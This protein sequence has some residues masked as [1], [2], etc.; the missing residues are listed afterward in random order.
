VGRRLDSGH[1]GEFQAENLPPNGLATKD[2]MTL[3]SAVAITTKILTTDVPS[4]AQPQLA[5]GEQAEADE[6]SP[7][8]TRINPDKSRD[9][10]VLIR[11]DEASGFVA[12]TRGRK[13]RPFDDPDRRKAEISTT[14]FTDRHEFQTNGSGLSVFIRVIRG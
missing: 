13:P 7:R 8:I 14:D 6:L 12:K 4:A 1:D 9:W 2:K 11:R 10:I 3:S 5:R